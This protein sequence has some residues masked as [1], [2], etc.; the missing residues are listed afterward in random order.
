MACMITCV[1]V[2]V[3]FA[4]QERFFSDEKSKKANDLRNETVED[5]AAEGEKGHVPI[6]QFSTVQRDDTLQ[7][8]SI[9]AEGINAKDNKEE[10]KTQDETSIILQTSQLHSN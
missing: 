6:L 3:P 5:M 9:M 1:G 7:D 2:E 8:A 4:I 10:K